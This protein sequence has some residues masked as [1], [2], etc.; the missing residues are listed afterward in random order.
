MVLGG[1]TVRHHI[2]TLRKE[3]HVFPYPPARLRW[4]SMRSEPEAERSQLLPNTHRS[5]TLP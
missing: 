1:L 4:V 5:T 2:A 3:A